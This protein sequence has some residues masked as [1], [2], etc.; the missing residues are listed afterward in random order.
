MKRLFVILSFG[1]LSISIGNGQT[2]DPAKPATPNPPPLPAA[3]P[4]MPPLKPLSVDE[5][6]KR[7]HK[8]EGSTFTKEKITSTVATGTFDLP[9]MGVTGTVEVYSKAPDKQLSI[10]NLKGYGV[11]T[12]AFDGVEGWSQD[13]T[14]GLRSKTGAELAHTKLASIFDRDAILTKLYPK[15]EV[16]GTDQVNG[17]D[18][19]VMTAT[20]TDAG[21]ETWYFDA[22]TFLMI[23]Q[24]AVADS[25]QGKIPIQ[26][27]F[28]DFRPVGGVM[29]PFLTRATNPS[30]TAVIKLTEIKTNVAIDDAKFKKPTAP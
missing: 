11:V 17:H 18:A 28:E 3:K 4:T 5:I 25:P 29:V 1:L 13:P 21:E 12:E 19:Y 7:Y 26:S 15:L 2:P 9:V 6:L 8:A 24:D 23:R 27:Y 22:T 30:Y 16:K 20:S 14:T 10:L